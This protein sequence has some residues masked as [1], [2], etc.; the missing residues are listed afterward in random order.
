MGGSTWRG[1]HGTQLAQPAPPHLRRAS[2]DRLAAPCCR[3]CS[4][5]PCPCFP[6]GC[7]FLGGASPPDACWGLLLGPGLSLPPAVPFR[8]ALPPSFPASMPACC[9]C[10]CWPFRCCPPAAT[11]PA[12]PPGAASASAAGSGAADAP[13]APGAASGMAWRRVHCRALASKACRWCLYSEV[14][15]PTTK[16]RGPLIMSAA[17]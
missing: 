5:L 1:H 8:A 12:P 11:G 3:H 10:S 9:S 17:G 16:H 14:C 7:S 2:R 15:T 6:C 13:A 4:W